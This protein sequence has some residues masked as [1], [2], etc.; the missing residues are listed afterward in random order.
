MK[1]LIFIFLLT[2][3]ITVS[4][5]GGCKKAEPPKPAETPAAAPTEPAPAPG[6]EGSK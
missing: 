6:E 5:I 3:L 4:F 1:K 2:A